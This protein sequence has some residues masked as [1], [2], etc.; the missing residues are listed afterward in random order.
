MSNVES[1]DK[2]HHAHRSGYGSTLTNLALQAEGPDESAWPRYRVLLMDVVSS[3]LFET[4]VG[5]FIILNLCLFVY[6]TDL[7][8]EPQSAEIPDWLE[9]ANVTLFVLYAMEV[10]VRLLA[11]QGEFFH[12]VLNWNT[13]DLSLVM[14]DCCLLIVRSI[15][16]DLKQSAFVRL[17]R[18]CRSLRIVKVLRMFPALRELYIMLHSLMGALKA[19]LWA[20]VMLVM[21]LTIFACAAVELINPL[22]RELSAENIFEGCDRCH[23]AFASVFDAQVTFFQQ[24]VAGD[25]WGLVTIPIIE[26]YPLTTPFFMLVV[27]TIQFGILNLIL[28]AIVDQANKAT[29]DD[30]YFQAMSRKQAYQ[31]AK[32]VLSQICKELDRDSSGTIKIDE[33]MEG[34]ETMPEFAH[35]MRFLDVSKNDINILFSVL[36][37]DGSGQVE[38]DEF[39][40]QLFK[41]QNQDIGVVIAFVR[42]YIQEICRVVHSHTKE[43]EAQKFRNEEVLRLLKQDAKASLQ[44]LNLS[45]FATSQQD[46]EQSFDH[47]VL[48]RFQ[49]LQESIEGMLVERRAPASTST[50]SSLSASCVTGTTTGSSFPASA[51]N[52][53]SFQQEDRRNSQLPV[54]GEKTGKVESASPPEPVAGRV[55]SVFFTQ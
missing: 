47:L 44:P 32:E 50:G 37:A 11:M 55:L 52:G 51:S 43:F 38:Y 23:R 54:H 31:K 49:A 48:L 39:I 25:S 53:S 27:V 20:A 33:L 6:E 40:E 29:E 16:P 19:M 15:I 18:I 41:M 21:V 28:A 46:L 22:V 30:T 13:F 1:D 17:L 8:A 5:A 45:Q 24:V 7:T 34:Y 4:A 3:T 9:A 12:G 14:M 2:D 10:A 42:S 26:R 35:Q 36:D